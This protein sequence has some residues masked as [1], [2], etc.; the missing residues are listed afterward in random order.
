MTELEEAM[1]Y[2]KNDRYAMETTGITIDEVKTHY[3]K[4]SL[5]IDNRHLNANDYVMGGVFFTLADFTFAVSSNRGSERTVTT[6]SMITYLGRVKGDTLISES[7]LIKS[8]G[9]M[10]TYEISV[11]DN[12]GNPIALVV[13]SG[14]YVKTA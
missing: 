2:F 10:C 13:T 12:L 9:T 8:G 5:K 14:M 7:R 1:T 6:N 11:R 4:C 3:A